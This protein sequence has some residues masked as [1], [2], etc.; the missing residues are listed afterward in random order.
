M[1]KPAKQN[2]AN[3]YS[4]TF[5]KE[6][7]ANIRSGRVRGFSKHF[8]KQNDLSFLLALPHAVSQYIDPQTSGIHVVVDQVAANEILDHGR[9]MALIPFILN[10]PD[11]DVKVTILNDKPIESQQ[12]QARHLIDYLIEKEHTG[13]FV[14]EVYQGSIT[15]L[16]E[17]DDID[18]YF[19]VSPKKQYL[20]QTSVQ[21][22][23]QRLVQSRTKV[24][25]GDIDRTALLFTLGV[26][27]QFSI[28]SHIPIL[29]NKA[30]L[31]FKAHMSKSL[32]HIGVTL[33]LDT[34]DP[35]VRLV[36][37]LQYSEDDIYQAS[38]HL[39]RIIN[40][41]DSL[42][43]APVYPFPLPVHFFDSVIIDFSTKDVQF[44]YEGDHYRFVMPHLHDF[45][46]DQFYDQDLN[47]IAQLYLYAIHIHRAVYNE[48][49]RLSVS[50]A[51]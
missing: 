19:S 6:L 29:K 49:K 50:K 47:H 12:T 10:R 33:E 17:L 35:H 1:K 41:G 20:N 44:S 2:N 3:P 18:V 27:N 16:D 37:G 4:D 45:E 39:T 11:M 25:I 36:N 26:Y 30:G 46:C 13:S 34:Y 40:Y 38:L 21:Q 15:D 14:S 22:V 5:F 42:R 23:L 28:A 43:N 48:F 24:V 7:T 32:S 8:V 51:S 9:W 31:S